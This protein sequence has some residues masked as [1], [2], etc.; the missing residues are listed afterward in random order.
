[1]R[2]L[3]ALLVCAFILV[4]VLHALADD[5]L[6]TLGAG[7]LVPLKTSKI[8]ME[9]ENLQISIHQITVDYI[10]RNTTDHAV[11]ATVVFPLPALDGAIV[12]YSPMNVPSKNPINFIDFKVAVN[13][14]WI[15]PRLQVRAVKNGKDITARLRSL[16]L[17]VSVLDPK[18][19]S[20]FFKLPARLR[21]QLEK[22]KLIGDQEYVGASGKTEHDVWGWWDTR[23]EYYWRQYFPAHSTVRVLHTYKPVVG[24]SYIVKGE[25]GEDVIQPYCG[26]PETLSQIARLKVRVRNE[27]GAVM[28]FERE[29]Q[30]ILTTANNWSGPIRHFHLSVLLD[31]PD[32]ILVTCMPGLKR[33]S[34]TKY[35]LNLSDFH[36]TSDLN[37][38]I[39]QP[40]KKGLTSPSN[41]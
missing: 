15:S 16:G 29:I 4:G 18:L 27:I 8:V 39:L 22:Q 1:M 19:Q 36:P 5:T 12:A 32:E 25:N 30:F 28:I 14:H 9:S 35:S 37:L 26:T 34:P 33:I 6:A 40:P 2:G 41:N 3:R 21:S 10:F 17:P 13:G 31:Q 23:I 7:G 20:D 11:D 24:G 38:L